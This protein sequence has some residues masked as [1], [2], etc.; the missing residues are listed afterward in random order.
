[1]RARRI[2]PPTTALQATTWR[3]TRA[4]CLPSCLAH[5]TDFLS[6][7]DRLTLLRDLNMLAEAGDVKESRALEAAQAF[8]AAPER[9]V[10]GQA[11]TIVDSASRLLPD[12]LQANYARFVRRLF[13]AQAAA[14]G[15][16]AK[17]ADDAETRLL[18]T[19]VVPFVARRG[20]DTA[21]LAEA[22]RLADGWLRDRKGVDPDM[23]RFVLSTAAWAGGQDFFDT[24]LRE[25]KKTEDLQQRQVMIGALGSFR[26]PQIARQSLDLMLAS[27]LDVKEGQGVFFGPLGNRETESSGI[28]ESRG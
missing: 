10:S 2:F 9:H 25:L 19:A 17:P 18:R 1:M 28:H 15:W 7:A 8:A 27:D 3:P 12:D 16:S 23:L 6:D 4:I 24:L 21:L 20:D 22:R 5:N 11:R 14:L 13:G 26:N